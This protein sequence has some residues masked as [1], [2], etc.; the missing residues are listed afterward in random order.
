MGSGALGDAEDQEH[1]GDCED[2]RGE[3]AAQFKAAVSDGL[4]EE[5]ADRCAERPGQDERCPE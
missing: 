3:W 5:V 2:K 4:V 1:D